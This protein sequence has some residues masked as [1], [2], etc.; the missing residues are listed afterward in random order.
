VDARG[1]GRLMLRR[2]ASGSRSAMVALVIG[3]AMPSAVFALAD[4]KSPRTSAAPAIE[5]PTLPVATPT[6]PPLPVATPT[7]PP[8]PV[9]TPTLPPLPVATP[10][11]PPLPV[12]TPTLP[13]PTPTL[14]LPTPTLPLPPPLPSLPLAT[15]LPTASTTPS[16]L[17]ASTE[18]PSPSAPATLA[19]ALGAGPV[20][21]SPPPSGP[22]VLPPT[23]ESPF[24]G[25]VLPGQLLGIPA[26]VL[27]LI[28]GIQ[29]VG[30]AAWLP[31]IRRWVNGGVGPWGDGR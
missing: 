4:L 31:V 6:L 2:S 24:L 16:A 15:V 22:D 19:P 12:A 23:T 5:L 27:A 18:P 10:T 14:P 29:L 13:L 8:L 26:F 30:G 21:P 9:A 11:L 1:L 3:L 25:F 20:V 7:L 28:L 17:P